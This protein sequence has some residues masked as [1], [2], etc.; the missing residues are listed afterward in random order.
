MSQ[1]SIL[2]STDA[3][4]YDD[5]QWHTVTATHDKEGLKLTVDDYEMFR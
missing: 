1:G 5:D 3:P 2:K 4:H